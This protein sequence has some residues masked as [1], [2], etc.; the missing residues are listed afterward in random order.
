[1]RKKRYAICGLSVRGI[2]HFVLPLLGKNRP[3]GTNFHDQAELVSI[4]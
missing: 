4:L 1:M 2:Y 3:G